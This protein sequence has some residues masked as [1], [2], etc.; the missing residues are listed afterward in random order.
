ML[1]KPNGIAPD[2]LPQI[3]IIS[4]LAVSDAVEKAVF[5]AAAGDIKIKWPNDVLLNEKKL[6]GILTE[7]CFLPNGEKY[8]IIGIGVNVLQKS[9]PDDISATATSLLIETKETEEVFSKKE[10]I[11]DIWEGFLSYYRD[12]QKTGDLSEMK[13]KYESRLI[14]IGRT[15][16]VLDPKGEYEAKALGID[17]RGRL[18]IEKEDKIFFIDSGEVSIRGILGYV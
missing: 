4:A 13:E 1:I 10:I 18:M 6:S 5:K 15:V 2:K 14:N 17:E 8:V 3:T 12:F 7:L 16:K 9:F 11:E